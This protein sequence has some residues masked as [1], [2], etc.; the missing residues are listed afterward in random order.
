MKEKELPKTVDIHQIVVDSTIEYE[1][2]EKEGKER[3]KK[4]KR[5]RKEG[6]LIESD[7]KTFL[8]LYLL[9]SS[10]SEKKGRRQVRRQLNDSQ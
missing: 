7:Q 9:T 4:K 1:R 5:K 10:L 6:S 2:E 3:K 8:Y